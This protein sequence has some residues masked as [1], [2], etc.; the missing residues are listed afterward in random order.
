MRIAIFAVLTLGTAC[1][2]GGGDACIG[3]E[4]CDCYGNGSCDDELD[5]RSN[6]C[7]DLGA[8]SGGGGGATST[9]GTGASDGGSDDVATGGAGGTSGGG[10]AGSDGGGGS[11]GSAGNDGSSGGSGCTPDCGDRECGPDPVCGESCG[12][13]S[14]GLE[15]KAGACQSTAPLK[16]NGDT[17]ADPSECASGDCLE[18]MIGERHCYGDGGPNDVCGDTYDCYGGA[19]IPR[20]FSGTGT[21]C[22]EGLVVCDALGIRGTCFEDLSLIA[23][24]HDHMCDPTTDFD[25]CVGFGCDWWFNNIAPADCPGQVNFYLSGQA[26]CL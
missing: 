9:A 4:G 5:C 11:N 18:N 3:A 17:C 1:S 10:G 12:A 26:S 7:I 2:G 20:T 6:T 21:V 24:Q 14:A 16:E 19:C 15:C 25:W 22:V 23:C 13:C 8:G